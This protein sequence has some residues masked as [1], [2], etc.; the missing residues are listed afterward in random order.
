MQ[1]QP[2]SSSLQ[3][4][5]APVRDQ[6]S[7]STIT[8][9]SSKTRR[10]YSTAPSTGP[11]RVQDRTSQDNNQRAPRLTATN[12]ERNIQ[13][14]AG[15]HNRNLAV[16]NWLS[17]RERQASVAA[18]YAQADAVV[19]RMARA[20]ITNGSQASGQGT[21]QSARQDFEVS[22]AGTWVDSPR[23]PQRPT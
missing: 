3:T 8:N 2:P 6:R 1:N 5:R 15:L 22:K 16:E 10:G 23:R 19:E 7:P 14:D 17:E 21:A 4:T 12:V 9:S 18:V 20:R 11:S 13:S